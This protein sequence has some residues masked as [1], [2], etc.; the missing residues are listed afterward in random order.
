[1]S[2]TLILIALL[3]VS[4]MALP[5]KLNNVDTMSV[6]TLMEIDPFGS[7]IISALALNITVESP[8]EDI[9]LLI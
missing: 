9:T 7:T 3:A 5:R 1:M 2:K 8:L 4:L 6:L